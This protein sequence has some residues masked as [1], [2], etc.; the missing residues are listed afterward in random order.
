[1]DPQSQCSRLGFKRF[2]LYVGIYLKQKT[3]DINVILPCPMYIKSM[4][5]SIRG[6]LSEVRERVNRM[7]IEVG[8]GGFMEETSV[9]RRVQEEIRN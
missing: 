5:I 9:G 4:R 8:S 1:M 3:S 7:N 2:F 6:I